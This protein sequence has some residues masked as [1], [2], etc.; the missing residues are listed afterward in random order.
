MI[1]NT[2]AI[3]GGQKVK[4]TPFGTGKRFGLEEATELLEALEQNTLFYHFGSKVKKFL[5]DFNDLYHVKYSV[6]TSSGTAALH[7]ALGAAGITVG[8][9]VITSPITDQGTVIGILYQNAI[10]I[11]ADLEPNSYNMTAEAIE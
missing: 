7:V 1:N 11:F 10:P 9:E 3:L 6:A 2:L 8:D 5:A 4:T